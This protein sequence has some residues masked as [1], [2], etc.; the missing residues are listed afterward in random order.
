MLITT[1]WLDYV[2]KS[3]EID[4]STY[5]ESGEWLLVETP[6]TRNVIKYQCCPEEYIDI[7]FTI[8]IRRRALYYGFNII[9]PCALISSLT[10]IM[11]L[12]PQDSGEKVSLGVTILLSLSVF[13]L[14][15]ADSVPTTS[16]SVPIVGVYFQTVM[17][18][19]TVSVVMAILI[20]NLHHRKPTMYIMP[21]WVK[22]YGTIFIYEYV[23][24]EDTDYK[25]SDEDKSK[26]LYKDD[27]M[28]ILMLIYLYEIAVRI[29]I[30]EWLAWI[31]HM[32]RPGKNL[33][34]EFLL[35]K[36]KI[37][38]FELQKPFS[39]SLISNI[40][41]VDNAIPQNHYLLHGA[42]INE[43]FKS[44]V[45]TESIIKNE[46]LE[47][48]N[49]LRFITHKIKDTDQTD[50]EIHDWKFAAMV[51]DRFCLIVFT[52]MT[53]LTTLGSGKHEEKLI[54]EIFV[55]RKLNK[56]ARPVENE[57]DAVD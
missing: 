10:M 13:S 26:C 45:S 28:M 30:C 42:C 12:L 27:L 22:M 36:A 53:V 31:L 47:I 1:T 48:L 54:D 7:T 41:N 29:V 21:K 15:V 20:L 23:E 11:F 38:K 18:M 35:R 6:V 24:M 2:L 34:R 33:S 44:Q 3:D 32:S 57:N 46:L 56:Y 19:C 4:R 16:M 39:L 52:L 25:M 40:K 50:G 8:H 51:I 49:E 55:T 14:I 9:V 17:L 5:Q 43:A 37:R